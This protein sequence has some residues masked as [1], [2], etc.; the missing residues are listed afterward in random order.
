MSEKII[1]E[2]Y[3]IIGNIYQNPDLLLEATK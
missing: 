2:D 1:D 3:E